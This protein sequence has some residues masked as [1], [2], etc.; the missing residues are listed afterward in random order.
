MNSLSNGRAISPRKP[1][2]RSDAKNGLV[3]SHKVARAIFPSST[4]RP[5][6]KSRADQKKEFDN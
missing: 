5:S 2:E 3:H 6:H 1:S 4:K